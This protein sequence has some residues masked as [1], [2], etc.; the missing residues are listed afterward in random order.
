MVHILVSKIVDALP[1]YRL[2]KQFRRLGIVLGRASMA[3]WTIKLANGCRILVDLLIEEAR[4][5]PAIQMDE[6]TI[7]VM[8]EKEMTK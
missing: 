1:F 2:E 8:G 6:T 5:R 3:A 4:N 7:Q